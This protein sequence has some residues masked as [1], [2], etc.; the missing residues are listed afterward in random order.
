MNAFCDRADLAKA[1]WNFSSN[2]ARSYNGFPIRQ[3]FKGRDAAG[4]AT[5]A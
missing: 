4:C 3:W 1:L 2:R 5:P